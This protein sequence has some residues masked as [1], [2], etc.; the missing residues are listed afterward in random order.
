MAV[1]AHL[2]SEHGTRVEMGHHDGPNDPY[3]KVACPF[4]DQ[5]AIQ[6][7]NPGG[8]DP[9]FLDEFADTVRLVAFDLLLFHLQDE[10]P[11][12]IGLEPVAR[13]AADSETA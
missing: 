5:E 4:C 11:E 6:S 3:F 12:K 13:Q 8:R 7:V 10:H 1:H 2:G 9:G